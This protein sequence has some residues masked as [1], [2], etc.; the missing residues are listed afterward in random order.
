MMMTTTRLKTKNLTRMTSDAEVMCLI[1]AYRINLIDD[2]NV[3][4]KQRLFIAAAAF[5][6]TPSQSEPSD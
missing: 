2:T 1:F 6:V 5:E 4:Y 3:C